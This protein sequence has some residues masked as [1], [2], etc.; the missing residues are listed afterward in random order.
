MSHLIDARNIFTKVFYNKYS[1]IFINQYMIFYLRNGK[2]YLKEEQFMCINLINVNI[3]GIYSSLPTILR[4]MK[5][6]QGNMSCLSIII[7]VR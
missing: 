3:K 4:Y 1:D 5:I 7:N 6:C 2:F